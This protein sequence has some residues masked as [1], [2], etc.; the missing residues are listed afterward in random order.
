MD[1]ENRWR[2]GDNSVV[3]RDVGAAA[4]FEAHFMGIGDA[5]RRMD[6]FG[7]AIDPLEPK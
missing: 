6:E 5:A 2:S 4:K 7:P 1:L 3:I